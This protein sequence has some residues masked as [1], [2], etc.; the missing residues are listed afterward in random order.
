MQRIWLRIALVV[1]FSLPAFTQAQNFVSI[2]TPSV[3]GKQEPHLRPTPAG[4][5]YYDSAFAHGYRH[6]YEEGFHIGDTDLQFGRAARDVTR[7]PEFTHEQG[8]MQSLGDRKLFRSGYREG[9]RSGYGDAVAGREFLASERTRAAAAG[10]IDV[11]HAE[12]RAAFDNGFAGGYL[13]ARA[14]TG[15][16]EGMTLEYVEQFCQKSPQSPEAHRAEYCSGF[17]R[18]YTLGLGDLGLPSAGVVAKEIPKH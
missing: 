13:S 11:L 17:S 12:Q 1:A 18:G 5:L 6:G 10:L 8:F 9:F 2:Q 4:A 15:S 3:P 14:H 16:A 7:F